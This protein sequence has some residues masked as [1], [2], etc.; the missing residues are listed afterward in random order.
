MVDHASWPRL[1]I[2]TDASDTCT[3][4]MDSP[5]GAERR[6]SGTGEPKIDSDT[7]NSW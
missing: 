7:C 1:A 5:N 3:V 6:G 4:Q 2:A